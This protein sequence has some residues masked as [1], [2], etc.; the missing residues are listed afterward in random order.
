LLESISNFTPVVSYDCPSGPSEIIVDGINGY[1]V[2]HLNKLDLIDKIKLALHSDWQ[3]DSLLESI[4][5]F[6]TKNVISSY[7]KALLRVN[8]SIDLEG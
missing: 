2:N 6:D 5:R 3:P 1:L 7:E 4:S 8:K